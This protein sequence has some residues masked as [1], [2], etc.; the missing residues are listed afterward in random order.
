MCPHSKASAEDVRREAMAANLGGG[1]YTFQYGDFGEIE[2]QPGAPFVGAGG[3]DLT[4]DLQGQDR[5]RK[6]K[7]AEPTERLEQK[8][9]MARQL[10]ERAKEGAEEEKQKKH[11]RRARKRRRR[12]RSSVSETSR[13]R[14]PPRRH[15]LKNI[16]MMPLSSSVPCCLFLTRFL[17]DLP[18]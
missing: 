5:S 18:D 15:D 13:S 16:C 1:S 4:S 11:K 17:T 8:R 3:A 12:R 9:G 7:I 14:S 2:R 10:F 6:L